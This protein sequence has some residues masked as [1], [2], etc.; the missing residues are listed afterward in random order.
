MKINHAT[1]AMLSDADRAW[2]DAAIAGTDA[3]TRAL[4]AA[5]ARAAGAVP[6]I[7]HALAQLAAF[8]PVVALAEDHLPRFVLRAGMSAAASSASSVRS[9]GIAVIPVY[10]AVMPRAGWLGTGMDSLRS[11]LRAHA[12]DSS[13]AAIVLDIDSP[14]GTVAG[15]PETAEAVAE[16]A[17]AK[18]VIAVANTL[19]ASAAY[20]IGSQASQFVAAPSADVGSIGAMALHVDISK[21]LSDAGISVTMIRSAPFKNEATLFSPLSDEA[22]AHIQGRVDEAGGDFLRSVAMGRKISQTKVKE[23]FGQGRVYGAREALSRG[24]V[25]RIAT[26]DQIVSELAQKPTPRRG[27]RRSAL[28]FE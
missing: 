9:G 24:M 16:A 6:T 8:D 21:M 26:L 11:Q 7:E 12:A 1:Y 18:P 13:V 22:K 3:A 17:K 20:W 28:S 4:A 14:G 19:A 10:G 2:V 15:T 23:D 25:D 5:D 27:A